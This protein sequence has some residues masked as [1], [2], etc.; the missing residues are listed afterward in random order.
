M[1]EVMRIV[2]LE[3]LFALGL[4]AAVAGCWFIDPRFGLV[5]G[6]VF[7]ALYS[8]RELMRLDG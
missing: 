2:L 6:G 4:S 1:G 3:I 7:L 8:W 5:V